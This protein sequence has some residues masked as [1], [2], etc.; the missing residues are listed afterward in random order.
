MLQHIGDSPNLLKDLASG[1]HPFVKV[2]F[3]FILNE[4]VKCHIEASE[5]F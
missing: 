1:N 4:P 3:I 2:R 5:V